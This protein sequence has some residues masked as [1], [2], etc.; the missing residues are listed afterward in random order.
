MTRSTRSAV[1]R[2]QFAGIAAVLALGALGTL[3]TDALGAAPLLGAV[4]VGGVTFA[5]PQGWRS[6]AEQATDDRALVRVFD[7]LAQAEIAR[8]VVA[9][10]ELVGDYEG[11]GTDELFAQLARECTPD[12]GAAWGQERRDMAGFVLAATCSLSSVDA[13]E[14]RVGRL[15][16]AVVLGVRCYIMA[17]LARPDDADAVLARAD[18][19]W[20]QAD[21]G[22]VV[23]SS[24]DSFKAGMLEDARRRYEQNPWYNPYW[25]VSDFSCSLNLDNP[26]A[27]YPDHMRYQYSTPEG[28][29]A[30]EDE[31]ELRQVTPLWGGDP[32][33]LW[34][35]PRVDSDGAPYVRS[36]VEVNGSRPSVQDI[37]FYEGFSDLWYIASTGAD[38]FLSGSGG[39]WWPYRD[40][41]TTAP[42]TPFFK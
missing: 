33:D 27:P 35:M 30:W 12:E 26:E 24:L 38:V 18:E 1:T 5:L 25:T 34:C 2:R 21:W 15:Y 22:A 40:P 16:T 31:I 13:G 4:R 17:V 3:T 39:T 8:V 29:T 28:V 37:A 9:S 7:P 32:V 14:L 23:E 20:N 19:L 10:S 41:D 42:W 36:T 6:D 11:L